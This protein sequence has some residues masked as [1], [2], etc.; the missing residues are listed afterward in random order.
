M[1]KQQIAFLFI[2]LLFTF[3]S[4]DLGNLVY[5]I[6][7][8]NFPWQSRQAQLVPGYQSTTTDLSDASE[9]ESDESAESED[10]TSTDDSQSVA[11]D[12]A[13]TDSSK[14][15]DANS[16]TSSETGESTTA[17]EA[18]VPA[19]T[20]SDLIPPIVT[21]VPGIPNTGALDA[22]T[23]VVALASGINNPLPSSTSLVI[24][25]DSGASTSPDTTTQE[26]AIPE[27]ID[28]TS[29]PSSTS[30]TDS[31]VATDTPDEIVS[32]DT[33]TPPES[34]APASSG[35]VFSTGAVTF[36]FDDGWSSQFDA[37]LPV[38]DAAEIK[39]TFYIVSR[40]LSDNGFS[41]FVS[42]AQV[43]QMAASGQDIGSHTKTHAHL[44]ALSTSA[45]QQEIAGAK[46]DLQAMGIN[47]QTF[48][49]PYG[50]YTSETV[51]IVRDAG[52]ASAVTTIEK[53]V[54]PS[55]DRFQV[56]APSV[57]ASHSPAQLEAM[58]DN[59]IANH[60][61]IILTFHRIDN[62]GDPYAITPENFQEVVSY[63][64][65]RGIPTVTV[66]QGAAFLQ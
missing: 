55:S 59:A 8:L 26:T 37:A 54:S 33:S 40:Q 42:A 34:V 21:S 11:T 23:S 49:Y 27:N 4:I 1:K 10:A 28:E 35:D 43:Q 57:L 16:A 46:E 50:E 51:Q 47:P 65:N 32:E 36:R 66:S 45:Q 56:E 22:A 2:P 5:Q 53:P 61:W 62:S 9:E 52:Y 24:E 19:L 38:L 14:L 12:T 13:P 41:G 44:P 64:K 30:T 20:L 15:A 18:A 31:A 6:H 3:N 60:Q 58:I 17:P 39:G 7:T 25:P 63:V 29:A 48:S